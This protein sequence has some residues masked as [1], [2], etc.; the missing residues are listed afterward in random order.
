MLATA[1]VL[2]VLTLLPRLSA[3][4]EEI[5]SEATREE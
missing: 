5:F 4:R 2:M 1:A 3:R